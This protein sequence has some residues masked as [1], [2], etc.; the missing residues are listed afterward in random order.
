MFDYLGSI[1]KPPEDVDKELIEILKKM[2]Q[3]NH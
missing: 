2:H 1:T 3:L